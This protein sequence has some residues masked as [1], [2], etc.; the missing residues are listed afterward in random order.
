MKS[1]AKNAVAV[2]FLISDGKV[3]KKQVEVD[4]RY[5]STPVIRSKS[6]S[7]KL[8]GQSVDQKYLI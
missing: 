5:F 2:R 8:E 3:P 4:R 7:L 6:K 1:R